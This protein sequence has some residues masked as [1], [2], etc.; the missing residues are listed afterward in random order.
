MFSGGLATWKGWR[1]IGFL[2]VYVGECAGSRSVGR[3][4][5]RRTVKE[6]EIS[7]P[8]KQGKWCRIGVSRGFMKGSA[9]FIAWGMNP[10]P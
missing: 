2:R 1:R 8:G 5:K 3:L 9:W 7:M 4:K 10:R 6:K